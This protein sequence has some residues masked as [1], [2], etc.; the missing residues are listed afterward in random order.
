[1]TIG[2]VAKTIAIARV[3]GSARPA[4][5]RC[6]PDVFIKLFIRHADNVMCVA[7]FQAFNDVRE[8]FT[9]QR[10]GCLCYTS[11]R[12]LQSSLIHYFHRLFKIT[13]SFMAIGKCWTTCLL[14]THMCTKHRHTVGRK[15]ILHWYNI[16][17]YMY[18][19][20]VQNVT[21]CQIKLQ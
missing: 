10:L 1:M 21:S 15:Y 7:S 13:F 14:P 3:R 6:P 17:K 12:N 5:S 11:F 4:R 18:V 8:T 19:C 9:S 16:N 20:T 2:K